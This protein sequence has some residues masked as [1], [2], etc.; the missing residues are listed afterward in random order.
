[1]IIIK[2]EAALPEE[3]SASVIE[4]SGAG[5]VDKTMKRLLER[6]EERGGAITEDETSDGGWPFFG[7]TLNC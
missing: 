1:M 3:K 6:A 5:C 2:L 7:F 4:K